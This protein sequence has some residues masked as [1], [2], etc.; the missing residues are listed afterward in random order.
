MPKNLYYVVVK[1]D[2][3]F[4]ARQK[5]NKEIL[6][7]FGKIKKW[8]FHFEWI[9]TFWDRSSEKQNEAT[10]SDRTYADLDMEELYMFL[11]RTSS[12][13]GQQ[14]LYA[15]LRNPKLAASQSNQLEK[16]IAI[17]TE[18]EKRQ[19]ACIIAL[20]QLDQIEAFHI[21]GLFQ[22]EHLAKPKWFWAIQLLST[23]SVLT[24][25]AA[26]FVP[27]VWVA[28]IFLLGIN[29]IVHYWNKNNILQYASSIP[30]LLILMR[31]SRELRK[32][33]K[34]QS[35]ALNESIQNL[36][37]MSLQLSLF[38][39]DKGLQSEFA[40]LIDAFLELIRALF[41]VEPLLFFHTMKKLEHL[42]SDIQTLFEFVGETDMA[43]SVDAL[44][45]TLPYYSHFNARSNEKVL[46]ADDIYHPLLLDPVSNSIDLVGKS[47]LLTGSN[48][49]GKTTFIRTVGV[50]A[51]CGM[52][53]NTCFAKSL[54]MP[55][56]NIHSSI[57]ISDDL[58]DEKSY[59]F[60]EV[61]T[62]KAMLDQSSKDQP[63]LFLMD[64]LFKGTNTRER[65]AAAKA[66]L[67]ALNEGN[68]LVF[69]ATHDI[70]LTELL[71]ES[72][73]LYHFSEVVEGESIKFDYLLKPGNL[74]NTNALRILELNGFPAHVMKEAYAVLARQKG[75]D[76]PDATLN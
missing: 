18:K 9:S 63:T 60:E 29:F 58:L 13:V 22:E 47:V 33:C 62:V 35:P 34:E 10:I 3:M 14:Y 67:Q 16:R 26:F 73:D 59:Y 36:D 39:L 41:M 71:Q 48:M 65:I 6:E 74:K 15:R 5:K 7:E 69:I 53:L 37:R 21:A 55:V 40:Q 24:A 27:K 12:K 20:S 52:V 75:S 19:K 30:Q 32:L 50:N 25:L 57:R 70:E 54:S 45:K 23:F 11:D 1:S 64:E 76:D 56:M 8:Y 44:R 46:Q 43:L 38:K 61:N 28:L 51:I 2:G 49:S 31:V 68:H 42:K 66:V 72:Y 4:W 17:I